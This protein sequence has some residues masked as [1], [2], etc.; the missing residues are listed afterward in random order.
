MRRITEKVALVALICIAT[1]FA[2]TTVLYMANVIPQ[3]NWAE[4]GVAG[5]LTIILAILFV[6]LAVYLIWV[7]FSTGANLKR[8][9]LYCD[10]E[11]ATSAN[12]K[13]V[14]NII[15]GCVKQVDGVKIRKTKITADDKQGFVLTLYVVIDS[16]DVQKNLDKLRCLLAGGFADALGLKFNSVNFVVERLSAK[17]TPDTARAEQMAN[18]LAEQRQ[19]A[20]D[21]YTDPLDTCADHTTADTTEPDDTD[22]TD[23]KSDDVA[24]DDTADDAN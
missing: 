2:A 20:D 1:V 19:Q 3:A 7:N 13:V 23:D 6:A 24:P 12:K 9:L 14:E 16:T 22:G 10:S 4:N 8:I 21:F 11:S 18:K 5:T 15:D 17:F